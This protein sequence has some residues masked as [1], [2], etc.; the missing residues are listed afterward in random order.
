[1]EAFNL[2]VDS[3]AEERITD[4]ISPSNNRISGYYII[5]IHV[6]HGFKETIWA[7]HFIDLGTLLQMGPVPKESP[8]QC[9]WKY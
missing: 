3:E 8:L 1:M 5:S 7:N 9:S 4:E 6:L 2:W